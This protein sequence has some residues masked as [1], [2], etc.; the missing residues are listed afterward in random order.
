MKKGFPMANAKSLSSV[1][2]IKTPQKRS[3]AAK[4]NGAAGRA[5]GEDLNRVS[6]A[7][8]LPSVIRAVMAAPPPT[9]Q[10]FMPPGKT[11]RVADRPRVANKSVKKRAALGAT[12]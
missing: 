8:P 12:A 11:P 1:V 2:A 9:G 6:G 3:T 4:I 5:H 7:A 10:P